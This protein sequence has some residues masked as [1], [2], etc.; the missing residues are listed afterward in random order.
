MAKILADT[1]ELEKIVTKLAGTVEN[2]GGWLNPDLMMVAR[3]GQLSIEAENVDHGSKII[4]ITKGMLIP[5]DKINLTIKDG[6]FNVDI[7]HPEQW[8]SVER[9]VTDITFEMFNISKKAEFQKES[10]FW[11]GMQD[12]TDTLDLLM[13]GRTQG[14]RLK[15]MIRQTK[16]KFMDFDLDHFIC[17]DFVKSRVLGHKNHETGM[18]NQV[19]MTIIDFLNHHAG[20]AYFNSN[21]TG[22]SVVCSQ[23]VGGSKECFAHYRPLDAFD[24]MLHYGFVDT[25]PAY[26]RSI[27][28]DLTVPGMG[29]I[30]V[31]SRS[32]LLNKNKLAKPIKDLSFFIP[33]INKNYDIVIASHLYIPGPKAPNALRR[34]LGV[35]VG[36]LSNHKIREEDGLKIIEKLERDVLEQNLAF[37]EELLSH[38]NQKPEALEKSMILR[39]VKLMTETQLENIKAYKC[40]DETRFVA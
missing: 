23:P 24:S 6:V 20:G 38:L 12:H 25:S 5:M 4:K 15:K 27:P 14:D 2:S 13:K 16:N 19:I 36:R 40:M 33:I 39:Q 17:D 22:I 35:L 1:P 7:P 18:I 8:T 21:E 31:K 3:D 34:V 29:K 37:Y 28:L 30:A 32:D 9:E 26:V 10:N 11:V